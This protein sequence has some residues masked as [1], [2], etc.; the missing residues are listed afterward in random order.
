MCSKESPNW[1]FRFSRLQQP[2]RQKRDNRSF[3]SCPCLHLKHGSRV[4]LDAYEYYFLNQIHHDPILMK[5]KK[6]RKHMLFQSFQKKWVPG[7]S[8]RITA[9]TLPL[10]AVKVSSK[11]TEVFS[12]E[13]LAL[14]TSSGTPTRSIKSK[15]SG[16]LGIRIPI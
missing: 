1:L 4:L 8:P 3:L 7:H 14:G 2:Y 6:R 12:P 13:T 9:A 16:L 11:E 15:T 10:K 5:R